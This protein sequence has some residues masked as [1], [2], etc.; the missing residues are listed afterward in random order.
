MYQSK[1]KCPACGSTW[2]MY[3]ALKDSLRCRTC[4]QE[5]VRDPKLTAEGDSCQRCG[6]AEGHPVHGDQRL[7]DYH[8]YDKVDKVKV[9]ENQP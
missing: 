2:T 6:L 3:L 8:V 4:G 9:K 1:P 5:F 7:S